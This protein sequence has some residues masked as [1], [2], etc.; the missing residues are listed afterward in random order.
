MTCPTVDVIAAA[1]W[2][3]QQS[4]IDADRMVAGG[5]S[6]GGY[7]TSV[8]LGRPHPFKALVAHAAVYNLYT[9]VGADFG[10]EIPRFGGFWTR[11]RKRFSARCHRISVP[12]ISPRPR[13]WC[14]A[15]ATCACR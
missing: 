14:T 15:S 8:I 12:G 6:Y 11:S 3:K 5:G 10:Y 2:L 9:Q 4:W 13:W 7:L 1:E